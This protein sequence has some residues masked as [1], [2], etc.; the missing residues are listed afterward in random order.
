MASGSL[1]EL[2]SGR[3]SRSFEYYRSALEQLPT[4]LRD[5]IMTCMLR[6]GRLT[7]DALPFLIR[8]GVI[9]SI[10]LNGNL[11]LTDAGVAT[12][13]ENT[14][15]SLR[16][17]SLC[18][19][20]LLTDAAVQSIARCINL[21]ILK[22]SECYRLTDSAFIEPH[23]KVLTN[24]KNLLE[25][26]VSGCFH[27]TD[28]TLEDI[29]MNCDDII[30][31]HFVNCDITNDG[32]EFLLKKCTKLQ[33]L[34][35]SNQ[36]RIESSTMELLSNC[37]NI[38]S[39]SLVGCYL[40][41]NKTL[42]TIVSNCK[43][44]TKLILR[45]CSSLSD[46]AVGYAVN[47][48]A[49]EELDLSWCQLD[50]TCFEGIETA[51]S[52]L[53][54]KRLVLSWCLRMKDEHIAQL[55]RHCSNLRALDISWRSHSPD[56]I[57]LESITTHGTQLLAL[58]MISCPVV[59]IESLYGL[60]KLTNLQVFD[61]SWSEKI[62]D[63]VLRSA[64]AAG[65]LKFIDISLAHSIH[66]TSGG[67]EELIARSPDL[68]KFT[69]AKCP[70]LESGVIRQL[71]MS[72]K[73]LQCLCISDIPALDQDFI[74]LSKRCN[75]LSV[76][77]IGGL[78]SLSSHAFRHLSNCKYLTTLSAPSTNIDDES[79]IAL[80]ENCRVLQTLYLNGCVK[81]T[82]KGFMSITKNCSYLQNVSV[83]KCT[84]LSANGFTSLSECRALKGLEA[85]GNPTLS[86]ASLI[87]IMQN[88]KGLQSLSV[89]DN[90]QLTDEFLGCI[91]VF[92]SSLTFLSIERCGSIS[93]QAIET[94]KNLM[95]N[96]KFKV[97]S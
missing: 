56:D 60:S 34:D 8:G 62:D 12:I 68:M 73:N 18:R 37:P 80:S 61:I 9:S 93:G 26:D 90:S 74:E 83:S 13:V 59:H 15:L 50:G 88:C 32:V 4:E 51:R 52:K 1:Q 30:E 14:H 35:L 10:T 44:I 86:N 40:L 54:F 65:K 71:A 29:A 38:T 76:I 84:S 57:L 49:L 89:A 58:E 85:I 43:L 75:K 5:L 87:Q 91:W 77:A 67:V 16:K 33:T 7:N 97:H 21:R 6:E 31:L 78:T 17:I 11:L 46:P 28:V 66:L 19:C 81:F 36:V 48:L 79:L 22:L 39:V 47:E 53:S 3:I 27:I 96:K 25:I 55:V 24:C 42:M 82:D 20:T 45:E 92:C 63:T 72:C 95:E 70:E 41:N 69:A 94:L 64:S 2:I 23:S